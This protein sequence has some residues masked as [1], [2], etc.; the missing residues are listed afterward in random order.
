M[1]LILGDNKTHRVQRGY[2]GKALS[3]RF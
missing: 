3:Q 1:D 2:A